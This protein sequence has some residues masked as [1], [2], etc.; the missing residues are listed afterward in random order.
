MG[1]ICRWETTGCRGVGEG[2]GGGMV[3]DKL[4]GCWGGEGDG[5]RQVIGVG[6]CRDGGGGGRD[7][8][9]KQGSCCFGLDFNKMRKAVLKGCT[10]YTFIH[11]C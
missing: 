6:G 3:A 11:F 4:Q 2:V 1:V 9:R 10:L 5:R 7:H 8:K